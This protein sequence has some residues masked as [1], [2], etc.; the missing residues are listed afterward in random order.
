[1]TKDKF[2]QFI[3][4]L[5]GEIERYMKGRNV[6]D[7]EMIAFVNEFSNF[8]IKTAESDLPE[9]LKSKIEKLDFKYSVGK[10]ERSYTYFFLA[11]LS[12]GLWAFI[13]RNRK[14]RKMVDALGAIRNDLNKIYRESILL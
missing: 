3:K 2:E 12:L 4:Y 14:K 13:I 7:Q 8:K 6:S 1:M 10:I 9:P 5:I 11:Y